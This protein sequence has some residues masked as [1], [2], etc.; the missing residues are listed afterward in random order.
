VRLF[1]VGLGRSINKIDLDKLVGEEAWGMNRCHLLYDQTKWRPTRWWWTDMPQHDWHMDEIEQHVY[2][3]KENCWIREDVGKWK[4]PFDHRTTL[5]EH[6]PE[7]VRYFRRCVAGSHSN[8]MCDFEWKPTDWSCCKLDDPD[9][10][11]LCKYGSGTSVMIQQAVAEGFN[12]II[13]LGWDCDFEAIPLGEVETSH[14]VPGYWPLEVDYP[15]AQADRMNQT[16]LEMHDMIE[17]ETKARGVKVYLATPGG[18]CN[19]HERIDYD[20]LF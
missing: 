5:G 14:A 8:A 9:D 11:V 17:R 12:P 6:P 2:E 13:G 18:N 20:S 10:T 15:Q 7:N 16:L 19:A 1:I 4:F 3:F